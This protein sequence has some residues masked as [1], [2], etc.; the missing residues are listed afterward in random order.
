MHFRFA[1]ESSGTP[2][3]FSNWDTNQPNE[4]GPDHSSDTENCVSVSVTSKKW[5]DT[6]C[7]KNLQFICE[8]LPV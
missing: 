4:L 7:S 8:T 3:I 2:T 5:M 1:Y 6:S